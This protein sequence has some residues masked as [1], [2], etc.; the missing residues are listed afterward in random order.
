MT[1][2]TIELNKEMRKEVAG[3]R[4]VGGIKNKIRGVIVSQL[5]FENIDGDLSIEDC[6]DVVSITC[7]TKG[8]YDYGT[9]SLTKSEVDQVI[10]FLQKWKSNNS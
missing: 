7:Q 3:S 8:S 2:V 1:F 4:P 9:Y 10:K 6:N 5:N